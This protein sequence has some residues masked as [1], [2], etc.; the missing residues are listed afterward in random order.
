[1]RSKLEIR[2]F[3]LDGRGDSI[4]NYQ[5]AKKGI[6]IKY[7]D[8]PSRD[9]EQD[10][11]DNAIDVMK[12]YKE[13]MIEEIGISEEREYLKG[14][15]GFY[16][17]NPFK[18]KL[19]YQEEIKYQKEGTALREAF[20]EFYK[21]LGLYNKPLTEALNKLK[22]NKMKTKKFYHT[23][24]FKEREITLL[25]AVKEDEKNIFSSTATVSITY[26]VRLHNDEEVEGL[27]KKI[28]LGRLEKGKLLDNFRVDMRFAFK[29][30]YL[31]GL[32]FCFENEIKRGDLEIVGVTSGVAKERR[33]DKEQASQ[34]TNENLEQ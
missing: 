12:Y 21:E 10:Y 14:L 27:T 11:I 24:D 22:Q 6:T 4:F 23:F 2:G 32:A 29:L 15:G 19:S 28:A 20:K 16:N 34:E 7:P 31:K 17:R 8:I 1:M 13:K 26:S 5:Y 9:R 18:G 33:T 3:N 30:A 25:L